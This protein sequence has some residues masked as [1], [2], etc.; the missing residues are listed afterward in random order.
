MNFSQ[1]NAS[2][3]RHDLKEWKSDSSSYS[4]ITEKPFI[5]HNLQHFMARNNKN[6]LKMKIKMRGAAGRGC[7]FRFRFLRFKEEKNEALTWKRS[8]IY[9]AGEKWF[10][11]R[12]S[13]SLKFFITIGLISCPVVGCEALAQS[14]FITQ[15]IFKNIKICC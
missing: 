15:I 8:W 7:L 5:F 4:I 13:T 2:N 10:R 12:V 14:K 3:C 11:V 6:T 9:C 1:T